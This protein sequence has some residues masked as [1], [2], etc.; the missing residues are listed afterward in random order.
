M[1]DFGFRYELLVLL[2]KVVVLLVRTIPMQMS[3]S[4]FSLGFLIFL[5]SAALHVG[6]PSP[7]PA[8]MAPSRTSTSIYWLL[9][10]WT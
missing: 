1:Q 9:K 2:V 6:G 10:D 7:V 8:G 5:P 3:V 4:P